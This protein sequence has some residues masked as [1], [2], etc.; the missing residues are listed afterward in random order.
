MWRSLH[1][2]DTAMPFTLHMRSHFESVIN[3]C[4]ISQEMLKGTGKLIWMVMEKKCSFCFFLLLF[5]VSIFF[6]FSPFFLV[7]L[8]PYFFLWVQLIYLKLLFIFAPPFR[9]LLS[10]GMNRFSSYLWSILSH[11]HEILINNQLNIFCV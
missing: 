2:W 4:F 5:S 7:L 11:F 9:D 10:L 6:S 3:I 1:T 8:Y